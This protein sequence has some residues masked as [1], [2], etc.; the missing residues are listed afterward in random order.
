MTDP[1]AEKVADC[2]ALRETLEEGRDHWRDH[3]LA[4]EDLLDDAPVP[5]RHNDGS[6]MFTE[7]RV[8]WLIDAWRDG[9]AP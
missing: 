1:W 9:G 6:R 3:C 5:R 4:V 2:E 8:G 7:H